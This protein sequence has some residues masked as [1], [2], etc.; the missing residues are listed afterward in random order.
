MHIYVYI[1]IHVGILGDMIE[2][3]QPENLWKVLV[4]DPMTTRIVS[5][6]IRMYDISDNGVSG[7][8]IYTYMH[9]Y[10]HV[11]AYRYAYMY[12]HYGTRLCIR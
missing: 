7:I 5:S 2:K 4:L 3:V 6:C 11:R 8:Y 10:A 12:A 1:Y 9:I